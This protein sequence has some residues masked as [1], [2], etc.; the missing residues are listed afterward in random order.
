MQIELSRVDPSRSPQDRLRPD[1]L[2]SDCPVLLS[3][4][5]VMR[6]PYE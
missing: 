3:Q 6:A 1:R 2:R 5:L 4:R